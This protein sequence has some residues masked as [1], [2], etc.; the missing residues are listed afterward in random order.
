VKIDLACFTNLKRFFADLAAAYTWRFL[1][2][3]FVINF[4]SKG[5]LYIIATSSM[6]PMFK[7]QGASASQL[8]MLMAISMSPW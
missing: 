1:V 7:N 2:V 5:I 3:L 4:F 8:Q 6:L